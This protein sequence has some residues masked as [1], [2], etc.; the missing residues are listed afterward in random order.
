MTVL[1]EADV[2]VVGG[3]IIGCA[4]AYH[5]AK[6]GRRVAVAEKSEVGAEASGR[7]GGGTRQQARH[8]AETPVAIFSASLWQ[9]LDRELGT[10]TEYRRG[11]NLWLAF[12]EA[13]HAAQYRLAPGQRAMGL[14]V[15]LLGR[16]EIGQIFPFLDTGGIAG[17]SYSPTCGNAN[18]ILTTR[19]YG[20]A[21]ARLG[22]EIF[23]HTEVLG[24]KQSGGA[25]FAL[26]TSRGEIRAP[27]ILNAAG[28]WAP[29]IARMAGLE[30]PIR[31][32]RDQVMVTEALGPICRP[33]VISDRVY[34]RQAA[35]GG[36]HIGTVNLPHSTFAQTTEPVDL[37]N[38]ARA[39]V[40]LIPS[41]RHVK[42][43]RSWG[44]TSEKTPDDIPI[45]GF[46]GEPEGFAIAAGF[47]GHGFALGP[48]VG[49]LMGE[50]LLG[51]P[52]TLPLADFNLSRFRGNP[53]G[54]PVPHWS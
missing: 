53:E 4:T 6:A 35:H 14:D 11:G 31:P 19:G 43:V 2:A 37:S 32:S 1:Y 41:L 8:P 9:D 52:S 27:I 30:L 29:E 51:Q 7:N 15:R 44:G 10:E 47:S 50:L 42:V 49:Q 5:L 24:V 26:L 36:F 12:T 38:A 22:A 33:F 20:R 28:A 25:V 48:A 40:E 45:L 18:P 34:F 16:E 13:E 21:A 23:E 39:F 46:A 17:G 54:T 3:G